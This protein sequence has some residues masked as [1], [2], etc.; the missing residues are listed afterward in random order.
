MRALPAYRPSWAGRKEAEQP[1]I[2]RGFLTE[3]ELSGSDDKVV[4]SHGLWQR[5]FGGDTNLVGQS[6]WLD[7]EK[8]IVVGVLRP[9]ALAKANVPNQL[10]TVPGGKHGQFTAEERVKIFA[11]IHEF[12]AKNGLGEK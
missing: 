7:G 8:R 9:K 4:L 1:N 10:V 2:G 11:S 5:R 6:I 3:E 12:L